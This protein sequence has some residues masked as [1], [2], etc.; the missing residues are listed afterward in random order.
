MKGLN[1]I[2]S[3]H[4]FQ[5]D[6]LDFYGEWESPTVIISDGPYGINGYRGDLKSPVG[7]DEWY[8]PHIAAWSAKS[9]PQTTLWFWNTELGWATVHP[10]LLKY[11]WEFKTCNVWDKGMSHVAGNTNTKT[12]SHLPVVSE[13][14]VQYIKKP[15]FKIGNRNL[16]MKDW[17][18]FEWERT[19]LPFSKTND[20][21]GVA[22]AATRKYFTKCH[23][24]Y[25]PPAEMFGKISDYANKYGNPVGRPYFSTDGVSPLSKD[26][27][28]KMKPKFHCP[29]GVTN[30][31]TT[32]QL[33]SSERLKK[34]L[35]ALHLNQKPLELIQRIIEMSSDKGDIVWDP[36]GGLFTSAISCLDT[37]RI[38]YSSE[39]T[40]EVF[41]EGQ[42][43]I[44]L[45]AS[46]S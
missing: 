9:T 2:S 30:V 14:C 41:N 5:G 45:R 36:F 27:W 32:A 17:L 21:C 38:C 16:S 29:F 22:N 25:M 10:I 6:S 20:A 42:R 26:D 35:K 18:R 44:K 23:L 3:I 7:L 40:P 43:R 12:I 24:W 11:G 4:L 19:G 39:I 13:V 15:T 33:R 1:Q 8:E 46:A 34:G 37:Q 31:W 28:E